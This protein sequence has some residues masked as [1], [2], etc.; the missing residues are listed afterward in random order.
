MTEYTYKTILISGGLQRANARELQSGQWHH[1]ARLLRIDMNN[2]RADVA[3]DYVSPNDACPDELPGIRFTAMHRHGDKIYLPTG[4]E[5]LVL[6]A[7]TLKQVDY[8]THPLFNDVHHVNVIDGKIHVVSTGLDSIFIIDPDDHSKMEQ[9]YIGLTPFNERFNIDTDYRKINSTM[10]HESH[11]NFVFKMAGKTWA[12]RLNQ[13][14]VVCLDDPTQSIRISE[15]PIHDGITVGDKIY[16]TA[17]N[18]RIIIFNPSK[19]AVEEIIDLNDLDTRKS[20]K[21]W[22]RGLYIDG[23][24]AYVGL[25]ALRNTKF[26]E[27]IKWA[28][29]KVTSDSIFSLP[30]RIAVYDLKARKLLKEYVFENQQQDAIFSILSV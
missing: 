21:G 28:V 25:S 29:N 2:D 14:D 12:T 3:L 16:F 7:A 23:D 24:I 1:T 19:M 8:I 26:K 4:T 27:K 10:P 20:P 13:H 22:C 5:V 11:P 15:T 9:R 6:D 17:V 18:A 30:T